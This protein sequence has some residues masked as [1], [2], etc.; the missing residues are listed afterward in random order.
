MPLGI[1]VA[2]NFTDKRG[3]VHTS[4]Y[5]TIVDAHIQPLIKFAEFRLDFYVDQAKAEEGDFN[6]AIESFP[7]A[8]RGAAYDANFAE[9]DLSL[10][11][12]TI[13]SRAE[14]AM[15]AAEDSGGNKIID[16]TIF[17]IV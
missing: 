16:N 2:Q 13:R 10:V 9:E 17:E 3:V 5:G 7:I 15:L 4:A 14:I 6:A 11:G 12:N 1:I 8:F